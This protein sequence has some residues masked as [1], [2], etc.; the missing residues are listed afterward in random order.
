[1]GQRAA[2]ERADQ[3]QRQHV[4]VRMALL[5][6]APQQPRQARAQHAQA[7]ED[8]R[9]DADRRAQ[10]R[11]PV[12]VR[13]GHRHGK[14]QRQPGQ[15]IGHRG[16]GQ[17]ELAHRRAGAT[18]V[19]EDARQ[20]RH[21]GDAD[22]RGQEHRERPERNPGR[23]E[24]RLQAG[25]DQQAQRHRQQHGQHADRAGGAQRAVRAG[26]QAQFGTH[27]QHEQHQAELAQR[28][29]RGQRIGG[30]QPL[31]PLRRHGT[32]QYRPQRQAGQHFPDH[33]RLAKPAQH[34]RQRPRRGQY[35]DQLQQQHL[36]S[37]RNYL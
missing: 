28:I 30:E 13:R 6:M 8:H 5:R 10:E 31:L 20:H 34:P 3:Q 4:A 29:Q 33:P 32:Q 1:M 36:P 21:R 16:A 27:D 23:G 19:L 18:R 14:R 17:G 26:R 25:G 37:P 22:G 15:H 11:G 24:A 7:Q 35:H 2:G 12:A 9:G